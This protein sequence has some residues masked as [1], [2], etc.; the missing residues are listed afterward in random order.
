[1]NRR[2]FVK[3]ASALSLLSIFKLNSLN[4]FPALF[5]KKS[6]SDID[7]FKKIIATF[8][9]EKYRKMKIGDLIAEI[10][11]SFLGVP[12]VG[13]TLEGDTVENCK[14]NFSG[15][16]CVTFY[17]NC[18]GLARIIKTE[19]NS[20]KDLINEITFTRYRNGKIGDYTTR[21]HYTSDW[22]FDNE[23]KSVVEDV[24]KKLNGEV[25]NLHV[26][27]MSE[28]SKSNKQLDNQILVR[29]IA[30]IED[31]INK[32]VYY[33]IPKNKIASI[34]NQI[35]TGDYIAIATNKKGLDY[36]H[37]GMAFVKN[38]KTHFLHASLMQKKVILDTTISE[39]V[40]TISTHIGITVVR[41][42]E[43]IIMR[44]FID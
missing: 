33:Y 39:Y 4:S 31:E 25:F 8:S 18:L 19:R 30:S 14:I 20:F 5:A 41:P 9:S 21:L 28:H 24:T 26:D 3:A 38:G 7:K 44:G 1:M 6:I 2:N 22:I 27:F 34:E 43:N 10:G 29:K 23:K 36:A 13:G 32:R 16:D 12:Y 37:V 40:N 42:K 35:Q 15:L 11:L 17:E